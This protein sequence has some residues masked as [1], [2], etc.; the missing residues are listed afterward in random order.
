MLH[1]IC[2][3]LYFTFYTLYF[4][5][6]ILY[7]IFYILYFIF[8]ILYFSF[9]SADHTSESSIVFRRVGHSTL[10]KSAI[11]GNYLYA[12]PEVNHILV[13]ESVLGSILGSVLGLGSVEEA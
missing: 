4:I 10:L 2:Y 9:I 5:L 11:G 1:F 8:Y 7:F 3:I 12:S 6:Y 13:L